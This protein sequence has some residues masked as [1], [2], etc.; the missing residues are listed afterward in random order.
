MKK[1]LL[2]VISML[3]FAS[4][5]WA[6]VPTSVLVDFAQAKFRWT[7]VK[8]V[9][10]GDVEWFTIK[11]GVSSGNYTITSSVNCPTCRDA[12]VS[13][14]VGV[15]GKYFCIITASNRFGESGPSSEVSFEAGSA[16]NG[17]VDVI[18]SNQ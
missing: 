17:V 15:P 7:W 12:L 10:K 13:S 6:Q 3:M 2:G 1:V 11:C 18:I 14:V 8:E 9:G 5:V 16:P 4:S